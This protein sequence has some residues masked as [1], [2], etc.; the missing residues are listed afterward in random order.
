MEGNERDGL[1]HAIGSARHVLSQRAI[2]LTNP[3]PIPAAAIR[4]RITCSAIDDLESSMIIKPKPSVIMPKETCAE[5]CRLRFFRCTRR[6]AYHPTYH[7]DNLV[8]AINLAHEYA[9]DDGCH[10]CPKGEGQ[11]PD[12]SQKRI[13]AKCLIIY[14]EEAT[15][16]KSISTKYS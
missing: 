4:G 1:E 9:A 10:R 14:R 3:G 16:R 8:V 11:G 6:A 7:E 15:D 13:G 5:R 12:T 2:V